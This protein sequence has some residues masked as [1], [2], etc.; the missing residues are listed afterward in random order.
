MHALLSLL[1]R[2]LDRARRRLLI[3]RRG[4]GALLAAAAV[5]AGLHAVSS[6]PETVP[7][8][9]AAADLPAGSVLERDDLR[10]AAYPAD[11][12]P[13]GALRSPGEAVGR[14][15]LAP[16]PAGLPIT[17]SQ[18]LGPR[19]LDGYPGR[20]AL[21]VRIDPAA[22]ALLRPGDR[23][24]L[25][26][27]DPQGGAA[28]ESVTGDALVVTVPRPAS[29]TGPAGEAG[30]LVVLAVRPSEAASVAAAAVSRFLTVLWTH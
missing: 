10:R 27:G 22:A 26:A 1:D 3:H 25:V 21:A 18:L 29:G 23:I 11:G 4:L 17:R 6:A 30:R 20:S 5:W 12:V 9:T 28:A 7:V 13:G 19:A 14:T 2:P 15:V 16:V 8:W 24:A